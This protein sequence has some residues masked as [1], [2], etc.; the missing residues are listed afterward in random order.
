[1]AIMCAALVQSQVQVCFER[2]L[3]DSLVDLHKQGDVG[4]EVQEV[5][6]PFAFSVKFVENLSGFVNKR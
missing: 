3:N 1:M 6:S 4:H 5:N 2:I